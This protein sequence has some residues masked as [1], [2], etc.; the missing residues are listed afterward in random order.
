[1]VTEAMAL[2][3]TTEREKERRGKRRREGSR[4]KDSLRMF[5][6]FFSSA[7]E[8]PLRKPEKN[9]S[10]CRGRT[11]CNVQESFQE[12][13]DVSRVILNPGVGKGEGKIDRKRKSCFGTSLVV[14]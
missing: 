5:F 11:Y 4:E 9:Y 2:D 6:F 13:E 12:E 14:Q 10:C 1:M 3:N 7:E 8:E